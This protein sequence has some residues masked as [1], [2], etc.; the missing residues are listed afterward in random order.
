MSSITVY[1]VVVVAITLIFLY[2]YQCQENFHQFQLAKIRT[3][4]FKYELKERELNMLKI[5]TQQC[6]VPDL[7]D[8]RS[9]Y[10]GSNYQ[11]SWNDTIGRCDVMT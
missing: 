8:P 3:L 1:I 7:N 6:P 5:R 2:V 11:C 9:C 4:E 10:F